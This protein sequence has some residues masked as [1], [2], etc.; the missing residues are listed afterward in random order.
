MRVKMSYSNCMFTRIKGYIHKYETHIGF[1]SVVG[2][3]IFDSLTLKSVDL[4]IDN[5]L[6]IA[7]IL[8]VFSGIA[9]LRYADNKGIETYREGVFAGVQFALGGLFSAFTVFYSRSGSLFV[10]WPFLLVLVLFM[11]S[12][13]F[14]KK[15]YAKFLVQFLV[16]Y[17][18]LFSYLIFSVPLVTKTIGPW[19]F[20]LSGL[21]SLGLVFLYSK[22]IGQKLIQDTVIHSRQTWTG[23]VLTYLLVV[24]FYFA[25]IIPPIPLSL[26]ES[27]VSTYISKS[28]SG[29]YVFADEGK[30]WYSFLPIADTLRISQGSPVYF[31]SS[32]FSPTDI[33]A[34]I[35][36]DWQY[37]N[38]TTA[39]W[40][41]VTKIRFPI[42]GGRKEGYRGYS[43][44]SN[45]YEG[46]WRV[47]VETEYGQLIGRKRFEIEYK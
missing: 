36:H 2:G 23:I 31:F 13:E 30:H 47:D 28:E 27:H 4:L 24:F 16:A 26:H 12:S 32:V 18:A 20:I 38:E 41:S 46:M 40:E 43:V 17:L 34:N 45:I 35:I 21:L 3:F 5:L 6:L 14:L 37:Y 22:Y 15:Y 39:R 7:Y 1:V 10:S 29:E 44:K 25:H 19:T 11:A 33:D 8:L 9:Y 42:E